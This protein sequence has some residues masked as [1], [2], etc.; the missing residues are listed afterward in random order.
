MKLRAVFEFNFCGDLGESIS[1]ILRSCFDSEYG[2]SKRIE[3]IFTSDKRLKESESK[4]AET[5][6]R[7]EQKI[8]G[9]CEVLSTIHEGEV[10]WIYSVLVQ[11]IEECMRGFYSIAV[12]KQIH[13]VISEV[14]RRY[15]NGRRDW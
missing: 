2:A 8:A 10:S 11:R 1:I 13:R 15:R 7:S 5:C 9:Y 14:V 4:E 3:G 6:N 12:S